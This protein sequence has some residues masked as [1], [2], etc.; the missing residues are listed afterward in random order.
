MK[1]KL[2]NT[3]TKV[4]TILENLT[5]LAG[6]AYNYIIDIELPAGVDSGEYNYVLM[7]DSDRP[8]ATGI[9]QIGLFVPEKT[10]YTAQTPGT[11][12]QYNG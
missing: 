4:V 7:D 10:T 12:I 1:L 3:V 9:A 6:S 8:L 5:D 2:S 11:Y